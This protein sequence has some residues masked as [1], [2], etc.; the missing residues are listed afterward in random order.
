MESQM[1]LHNWPITTES[2]AEPGI[3]Q[4]LPLFDWYSVSGQK[5]KCV[6]PPV[7]HITDTLS[8][9][10][11]SMSMWPPK[12][13]AQINP[14]NNKTPKGTCYLPPNTEPNS[15]QKISMC[16][17]ICCIAKIC[18]YNVNWKCVDMCKGSW[19]TVQKQEKDLAAH[20][21]MVKLLQKVENTRQNNRNSNKLTKKKWNL[22]KMKLALW[23]PTFIPPK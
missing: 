16:Q 4:N 3:S 15:F 22:G 18:Q 7:Q 20:S 19:S 2:I 6:G 12:K 9:N 5:R 23:D 1:E 10:Y 21:L 14:N 11:A 8:P 13:R 17:A